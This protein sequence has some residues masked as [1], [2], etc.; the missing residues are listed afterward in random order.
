MMKKFFFSSPLTAA[1]LTA[2]TFAAC[3]QSDTIADGNSVNNANN[4]PQA[5]EFGTYMG[6][7][8]TRATTDQ[9][10]S[11]GP[12]GNTAD[13]PNKVKSLAQAQFAVFGYYTGAKNYREN[14]NTWGTGTWKNDETNK[15][16]NFM[17]NQK[18]EWSTSEPT[19][20][21]IYSPVKYWPNGIDAANTTA[22]P[23]NT[24]IQNAE[25]KLS[26]FAYAPY[27]TEGTT[28]TA[29]TDI[30]TG[31]SAKNV[32]NP[33]QI[34]INS[35]PTDNGIVAISDNTSPTDVWVK[36]MMPV[37][38]E[39]KAVD[40]LWGIR[41]KKDYAETDATNNTVTALSGDLYNTDLTKQTTP[42][43]VKFLFKHA[44]AKIG[45]TKSTATEDIN[46][47]PASCAFKVV[48][49]IDKNSDAPKTGGQSD[50]RTYF[51]EDFSNEKTLVTL[52]EVKIRD[53]ASVVEAN[54]VTGIT[55][56][57]SN[58]YKSG[59]FDIE[60][61]TWDTT[62][63]ATGAT[64]NIVANN[65]S[66]NDANT[67]DQNY[68]LNVKI[69]EIGAKRNGETG[70]GKALETGNDSWNAS[71]NPV[72][73]TLDPTDVFANENVP[74]LMLIPGTNADI[75]ITV[76]YVVRTADPKLAAGFSEVEQT[77]TNKVSL[78]SLQSNKVYTIIMHLGLTSVKF[79]AVVADW[80]TNNATEY[81]ENGTVVTPT[82]PTENKE[83]IWLPSNVV[84]ATST[85]NP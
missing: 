72:G 83:V 24:A 51:N 4:A 8:G 61:G 16:P 2:L 66:T 55:S 5:V 45:G 14:Q 42:E 68:S 43:R 44:L 73:V 53:L 54:D 57:T 23:S 58:L 81:N 18:L 10:Y 11:S 34:T 56:G 62:N 32:A 71:E 76:T 7:Q 13:E 69:K 31:V 74:G 64:Y 78:A 3:S 49:D 67:T 22:N 60:N 41:G 50:Q 85:P 33:K 25:A 48:V 36:Y 47:Q 29:G 80:E 70:N 30:P 17:Y 37:A 63:A 75:Y 40:L 6:A 20:V 39:D 84:T 46:G 52:K 21:W 1:V 26:F 19:D 82:T 77:I 12:I 59:W 79:E 65:T 9:D 15:Y 35:T 27:M 38:E 28:P